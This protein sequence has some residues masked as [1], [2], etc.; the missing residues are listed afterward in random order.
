V[1]LLQVLVGMLGWWCDGDGYWVAGRVA[2]WAALG[3][4]LTLARRLLVLQNPFFRRGT[5]VV[6][7]TTEGAAELQRVAVHKADQHLTYFFSGCYDNSIL[8]S[9]P[10]TGWAAQRRLIHAHIAACSSRFSALAA[11]AAAEIAAGAAAEACTPR[12]VS[13]R[14]E[15]GQRVAAISAAALGAT[16]TVPTA[17][18]TVCGND[19][20]ECAGGAGSD[21]R[22]IPPPPPL[23]SPMDHDAMGVVSFVVHG[24]HAVLLLD[25]VG[26][27][28]VLWVALVRPLATLCRARLRHDQLLR[29]WL[30][31]S[32]AEFA[33]Q[34]LAAC[35]GNEEEALGHL[36]VLTLG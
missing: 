24:M 1:L 18:A 10:S 22:R 20:G 25:A 7:A 14:E 17:A 11:A 8:M 4:L 29:R 5:T 36:W 35:A 13:L 2:E 21:E 23:S 33:R 16:P 32:G 28:P 3:C 34:L 6:V 15:V 27:L 19:R 9:L 26:L 30:R 12:V 31:G